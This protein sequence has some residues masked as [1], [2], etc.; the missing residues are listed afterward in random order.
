MIEEETM[1][2]IIKAGKE[3]V[4]VEAEA[5]EE[6][7]EEIMEK[8][9]A[10]MAREEAKVMKMNKGDNVAVEEEEEEIERIEAI[11]K[12]M[13]MVKEIKGESTRI[14]KPVDFQKTKSKQN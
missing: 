11:G 14:R 9:D 12:E 5:E 3:E 6:G 10:I 1:A 13:T 4:A 8:V 2:M 7:E